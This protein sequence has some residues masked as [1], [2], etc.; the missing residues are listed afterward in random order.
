MIGPEVETVQARIYHGDHEAR[1]ILVMAAPWGMKI[2]TVENFLQKLNDRGIAPTNGRLFP[3][4]KF[5]YKAPRSQLTEIVVTGK[6][7]DKGNAIVEFIEAG[8][9]FVIRHFHLFECKV[10]SPGVCK[11]EGADL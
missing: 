2:E 3:A 1:S 4:C 5:Y 11:E 10:H 8:T 7:D 9:P 6:G